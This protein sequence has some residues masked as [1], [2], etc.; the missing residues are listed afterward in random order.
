MLKVNPKGVNPAKYVDLEP[1]YDERNIFES[2]NKTVVLTF[3]R[4]SPP[5]IGHEKLVDRIKDEAT[6]RKADA[7]VYASHT[8]DK[9]KNPLT[10]EQ[11]INFLK[12]A[13]GNIVKVS[14]SKTVIDVAKELDSRY[15]NFILIVGKDRVPEFE[16]LLNT[17]NGKEYNYKTI[18]VI[19]AGDR[20]PDA[21]DV[22][23]MS[24]SKLR[25][26]AV[27]GDFEKF[28][29]GI[30][31]K[32]KSHAKEV[33]D[34]VLKGMKLMEDIE[35]EDNT[36]EE[37][38]SPLTFAQRI[39]RSMVMK[40]YRGK[41]EAARKRAQLRRASPEK[42][43]DRARKKA[44]VMLRDRLSKAKSYSD[45]S[46]SE[47][48]ALDQRLSRIPQAVINRI[49]VKQI[50][51]VKKAEA[52]R[53][54]SLRS[55]KNEE[56]DLDR[57]FEVFLENFTQETSVNEDYY[58]GLS[59]STA[60]KRRAHFKR[61]ASM[62][63]ENPAAYTPAPGDARAETKPSVYT[64]RYHKVFTKEGRVKHDMRFK[65]Y[66]PKK[67]MF[68]SVED[69]EEELYDLI[70]SVESLFEDS[71]TGL[72]KKASETGISYGI[73]KKVYDRGVA[74]W[75][76]GHRPGTT[77]SQ[78]G[79]ARV[80][81]FATGG[82]T[83]TTADAD[84]WAKH[85]G[86]NESV[87]E[88]CWDGYTQVG[89]K[90][91]GDRTVPNCVK[92]GQA[93]DLAKASI[94]RE[95]LAD[96]EK[97]KNMM[98]NARKIDAKRKALRTES[99]EV[100]QKIIAR[101]KKHKEIAKAIKDFS[102]KAKDLNPSDHLYHAAKIVK[103]HDISMS[104]SDLVKLYN[105]IRNSKNYEKSYTV[106][107]AWESVDKAN[108]ANREYGTDSLVKI[109]KGDTPGE[110]E[111]LKETKFIPPIKHAKTTVPDFVEP[112]TPDIA[113]VV[114]KHNKHQLGVGLNLKQMIQHALKSRDTDADGDV[115]AQDKKVVGG[116]ELVADP[117]FDKTKTPGEATS[118]MKQKYEKEGQH[119]KP[120]LAFESV[121][122]KFENF[123][124]AKARGFEG[125]LVDVP[126]VPVRMA[127]GK[128]KSFPSG[129]SSSS[130][131]GDGE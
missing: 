38:V 47:K 66:K 58:A 24:A 99:S 31:K 115:D 23:G 41:I 51:I 129:K 75:R 92:E 20:D 25:Q 3:G 44:L 93:T 4:F 126:N 10:Y 35:N 65:M 90:K 28:K 45:M 111:N 80:N 77:P 113:A 40:R 37:K 73:L 109:L 61:G 64:K 102:E 101:E 6:K 131:G 36:L 112:K 67:S 82:K 43:R 56:V 53:I 70:E 110:K 91:K 55:G 74:A 130:D 124:E 16:R 22:T 42:L 7:F 21:E 87:D 128:L 62:S 117:S 114:S 57:E 78:W 54:A 116:G 105:R 106:F 104:A 32:L 69:Y 122:D 27:S 33:Y 119:T 8:F 15:D 59:K 71:E 60:A 120:G 11:K 19:S 12:I 2:K 18:E 121:D 79:Y 76:T 39:K 29:L 1:K 9:K 118:K 103:S 95:K 125:K 123:L 84:L 96:A 46:P 94:E 86:K 107:D 50:P 127:N 30:P 49:A 68:E 17:Y 5:T 98:S 48:I 97:H 85:K 89:M 72:K 63:D 81:S 108:P 52:E 83:R 100:I 26:L 14:N 13:F 88:A 34:S